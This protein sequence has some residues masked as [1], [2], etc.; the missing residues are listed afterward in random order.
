M[1]EDR[2]NY[3]YYLVREDI[4]PESIIKTARVKELLAKGEASNV[5][6]AVN[7]LGLAR[8]T[9]YKYKD[10]VWPFFD[11]ANL[12]I[13]N[14]SLL[15]NHVSGVLSRVLNLVA[16]LK[17]NVLTINQSLPLHGVAYVTLSLSIEE[18]TVS[19]DEFLLALNKLEGVI[20]AEI[21][22]KS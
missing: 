18:M 8:S 11:A 4:L 7:K 16:S 1:S 17:A 22:G 2:K 9:Y 21:V 12:H 15:L 10:G 5:L 20:R 13:I 3:N 14:V 19:V 6:E